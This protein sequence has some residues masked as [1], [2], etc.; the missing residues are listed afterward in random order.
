MSTT[1][2]LEVMGSE[3]QRAKEV[4]MGEGRDSVCESWK[5]LRNV[6]KQ[7]L[8]MINWLGNLYKCDEWVLLLQY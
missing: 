2:A 6:R 7:V 5:C 4:V 8:L 1:M 3:Q